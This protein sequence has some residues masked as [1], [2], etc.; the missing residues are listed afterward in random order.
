M[1]FPPQKA[2]PN[3]FL[4]LSTVINHNHSNLKRLIEKASPSRLLVESDYNNIDKCTSQTLQILQ[5]I[6]EVKGWA[7]EEEWNDELEESKW[8]AVRRLAENW[9]R[10]RDGDHPVPGGSKRARKKKLQ[11]RAS[12]AESGSST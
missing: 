12:E 10:F 4:S 1:L 2:L 9:K 8:G 3:I 6:A 11:D 7:I 5:F